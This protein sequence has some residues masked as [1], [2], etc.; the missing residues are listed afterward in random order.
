VLNRSAAIR[1]FL[2]AF[3]LLFGPGSDGRRLPVIAG[4]DRPICRV[5][6]GI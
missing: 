2:I 4:L 1:I 3:L 5:L 6:G